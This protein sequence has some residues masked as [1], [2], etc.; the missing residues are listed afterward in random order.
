MFYYK[1]FCLV[2]ASPLSWK[3]TIVRWR[4]AAFFMH[5]YFF[6]LSFEM[7]FSALFY[8]SNSTALYERWWQNIIYESRPGKN[9]PFYLWHHLL[10]QQLGFHVCTFMFS[11]KWQPASLPPGSTFLFSQKENPETETEMS[12]LDKQQKN[13]KSTVLSQEFV[14]S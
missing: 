7:A 2:I 6:L 11:S 8:Y 1:V 10:C 3:V 13:K 5:C 4:M 14:K 9:V 12:S